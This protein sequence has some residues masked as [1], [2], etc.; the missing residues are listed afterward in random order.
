MHSGG[1]ITRSSGLAPEG[2]RVNSEQ[3][4]GT[5]LRSPRCRL[6]APRLR[7]LQSIG[8]EADGFDLL[9]GRDDEPLL[10]GPDQFYLG[11][12]RGPSGRSPDRLRPGSP[13]RTGPWAYL[14]GTEADRG[15]ARPG[16]TPPATRT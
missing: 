2:R 11:R 15:I 4:T 7:G 10:I 9:P 3:D 14:P 5:G 8:D 6:S 16:R 1:L 12:R 13:L